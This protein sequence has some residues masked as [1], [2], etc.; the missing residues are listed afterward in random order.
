MRTLSALMHRD[1]ERVHA[2]SCRVVLSAHTVGL[3][4]IALA[5]GDSVL[6]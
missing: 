1:L 3:R 5:F 6:A 4:G 2:M